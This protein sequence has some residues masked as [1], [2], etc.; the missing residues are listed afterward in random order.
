MPLNMFNWNLDNLKLSKIGAICFKRLPFV[1]GGVNTMGSTLQYLQ[2]PMVDVRTCADAYA[3][4][5]ANSRTPVIIT[6]SQICAQGS[7]SGDTCQGV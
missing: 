3:R 6:E 1:S 4:F 7:T 5:S 2:L